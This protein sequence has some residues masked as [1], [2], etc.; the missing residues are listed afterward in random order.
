MNKSRILYT[1]TEVRNSIIELFA[2]SKGRRVAITAFVGKGAEAYLPK[3]DGLELVCWPKAGGTNPYTL[4]KLVKRGVQVSFVDSLHM[5]VYWAEDRGA[6][7][8]SANLSTNALGA[9]NLHEFGVFLPAN[10]IEIDKILSSLKQRPI[11][12]QELLQLDKLHHEYE[13]QTASHPTRRQGITF[14]EW[15]KLPFRPAWKLGWWDTYSSACSTAEKVT[16]EEYGI[17]TPH[18]FMN[19]QRND[20]KKNDWMLSFRLKGKSPS[21][22]RW[23]PIDDVVPIPK[24]DK[25][26]YTPEYPYQAIQ[27]WSLSHYP[28]PPFR[29][30]QQFR[31]AFSKAVR[32]LDAES[33]KESDPIKPSKWLVDFLYNN[34]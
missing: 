15:Y 9:G 34:Y 2:S 29:I 22:I 16:R 33:I 19:C 32:E 6:I 25:K 8:T 20:Y 13:L 24:S 31:L 26:I 23:M 11:S 27:V 3:P 7:V 1:S 21:A 5:K 10:Q 17:S 12:H 4:R 28:A 18:D 14:S 30:D